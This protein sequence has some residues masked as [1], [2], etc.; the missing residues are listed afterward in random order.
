M[1]IFLFITLVLFFCYENVLSQVTHYTIK[2][3]KSKEIN[4]NDLYSERYLCFENAMYDSAFIPYYYSINSVNNNSFEYELLDFETAELK[5]EDIKYLPQN[6]INSISAKPFFYSG[7]S[8]QRKQPFLYFKL[9]PFVKKNGKV[10]KI[11]SFSINKVINKSVIK[12]NKNVNKDF[13]NSSV[14]ATGEWYKLAI[15]STGVCKLSYDYLNSLGIDVDNIDPKKIKI[16][17]N[18]SGMLPVM[19]NEE[20]FDDLVENAIYVTGEGDGVFNS[21]DY[22]LFYAESPDEWRYNASSQHFEHVF[23]KYATYNYYYLTIDGNNGKR[24]ENQASLQ[25]AEDY[26][27]S[28]YDALYYWENEYE[29]LLKSGKEWF[30]EKFEMVNSYDTTFSTPYIIDTA[31]HYIRASVVA[32]SDKTSSFNIKI[33]NNSVYTVSVAPVSITSYTNSYAAYGYAAGNFSSSSNS[34]NVSLQYVFNTSS[35]TAIGWLNYLELNVKR[36]LRLSGGQL[37]FRDVDAYNNATVCKYQLSNVSS[38]ITVWDVSDLQNIKKQEGTINN[39]VFEFKSAADE[40]KT[41]VAFDGSSYSTPVSSKKIDNQNLHG[42]SGIDYIIISHPNFISQ[43][44]QLAQLHESRHGFSTVIVTPEQIYNEFSSGKPDVTALRD[45]VRMLYV[46]AATDD[47]LPDYLLLFGDGSYDYKNRVSPNTNYILSYQSN[48]SLS[49][50]NSYTSDDYYALLDTNEGNWSNNDLV[51][52]GIGRFPVKTTEEAQSLVN[53]IDRYTL[54]QKVAYNSSVC[55]G[56]SVFISNYADWRNTVCFVADDQDGNLHINQADATAIKVDTSYSDYIVD[57]IYLDAYKQVSTPGGQRYYDA[58]EAFVKRVDKGALI[59]N[60]TGHG[61]EVGLAHERVLEI[62]HINNWNNKYNLPLFVTATC[63]FSRFDDP[64]R[65][66]A[67][68]LVLL[69]EDG[70]G[71][72]LLTTVRLALASYNDNLNRAFYDYAFERNAD[73]KYYTIG[74]LYRLTKCKVGSNVH[75]R[76]FTLLGDPGVTLAYPKYE[77][78]T[79]HINN[80]P[81]TQS[82]DTLK[83]FKK[84]TVKGYV[85]DEN[86]QILSDFNGLIYPTV[87]DKKSTYTTIGNDDD[88]YPRNF[89]LQNNILY[90]GKAS[91]NNGNFEFTFI[92]PKDISYNYGKGKI[93]YYSENGTL[94]ANGSFEDIIIG[95]TMDSA[96]IDKQAP[97]VQLYLNNEQFV[98]GSLTNE[99]PILLAKVFDSSG[100]NT[101]GNGIGHDIVAVLDGNTEKSIVLNDYYEADLDSYQSGVVKYPFSELSEGKHTLKIKVW[102]VYNNS[103]EE[104]IEFEVVKSTELLLEH[105]LNYPNPFSNYTE[106]YFEHNQ[107]CCYLDVK[108]DIFTVS[109]RLVKTILEQVQTNGFRISP[110]IWDGTDEYGEELAR[111]VYVYS[112]QVKNKE[113]QTVK[114]FEKLV[115]L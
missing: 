112:V 32:R 87:Y 68:E 44:N 30:G 100:I 86:N 38:N 85:S 102:D 80:I 53:K 59:V 75:Y 95:G 49:P 67:G 21:T 96:D 73:G 106:F 81:I 79:T 16:Y 56:S 7:V 33:N 28:S 55:E 24:I 13:S 101:V 34:L 58:T 50:T 37:L 43:A 14:L 57:K 108:I 93:S 1:K 5:N 89:T 71:I 78:E 26:V 99:T 115:K 88:S 25:Q 84:V 40:L 72:A 18:G 109:G 3:D 8:I 76:N 70:G 64:D 48:N 110:I 107:P 22:V 104:E 83:A 97:N 11:T 105:V 46:R 61:G 20:R 9:Y 52:I 54:Q 27:S 15:N 66:S 77:I 47:D 63:E 114:V 62:S 92:V 4:L 69:K 31:Q 94:D 113:G 111:G 36:Q 41:Y 42:L 29:N 82:L 23:H 2:W 91:V 51:D 6:F 65:T 35:S 19:N 60:Y 90:K 17:G 103:N 12:K 39:N 98:N 45:F 10:F 74:D